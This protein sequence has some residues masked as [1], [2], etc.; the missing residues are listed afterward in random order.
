MIVPYYRGKNSELLQV[1]DYLQR[2]GVKFEYDA[3]G[4]EAARTYRN[5]V[6]QEMDFTP[7]GRHH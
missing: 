2:M 7:L 3:M 6:R 1:I 5:G 4:R